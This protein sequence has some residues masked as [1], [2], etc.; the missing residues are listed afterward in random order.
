MT[1]HDEIVNLSKEF[2]EKLFLSGFME[3][4]ITNSDFKKVN[5]NVCNR[6]MDV[7]KHENAPYYCYRCDEEAEQV[8]R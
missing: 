6:I 7:R 3:K 1:N 2:R 4:T 5:C 8:Q